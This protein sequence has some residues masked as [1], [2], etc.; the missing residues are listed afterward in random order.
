LRARGIDD[1]AAYL[2]ELSEVKQEESKCL[3]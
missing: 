2:Q 1:W 3:P